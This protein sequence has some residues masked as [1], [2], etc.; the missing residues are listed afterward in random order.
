MG[1]HSNVLFWRF[2]AYNKYINE[3]L[4]EELVQHV[5]LTHIIVKIQYLNL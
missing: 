5:S 2:F 3:T 4:F 1:S